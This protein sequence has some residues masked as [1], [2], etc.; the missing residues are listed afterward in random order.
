MRRQVFPTAPSPT[1][2][3]LMNLLGTVLIWSLPPTTLSLSNLIFLLTNLF[4]FPV[5]YGNLAPTTT[6]FQ[7]TLILSITPSQIP[8]LNCRE[9]EKSWKFSMSFSR[10][11]R[12]VVTLFWAVREAKGGKRG[13]Q[14][15]G[16]VCDIAFSNN[17]YNWRVVLNTS[18]LWAS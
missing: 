13:N 8:S 16:D 2:T 9:R 12:S 15:P 17:N 10:R 7:G 14:A 11:K 1:V 18:H 3:H 6:P 5:V 4:S